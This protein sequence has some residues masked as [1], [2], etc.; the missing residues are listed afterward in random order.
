M[1]RYTL[2]TKKEGFY[3]IT[4]AV[5]TAVRRS[6]IDDG[7]A[8]VFCPHTTAGITINE[9][10]DPDVVQDMLTGLDKACRGKFRRPSESVGGRKLSCGNYTERQACP[11]NV[12]GYLFY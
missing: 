1:D 9:N 2:N 10:A 8:V 3:N 12:A 7:I 6:G 11:G 5:S 4:E